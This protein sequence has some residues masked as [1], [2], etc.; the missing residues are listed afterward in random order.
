M[1]REALKLVR[2]IAAFTV[3]LFILF[4][5]PALSYG[6]G[7]TILAE[8]VRVNDGDTISVVLGGRREKVRLIG[9]DAPELHQRPWGMRAKRRLEELLNN[10][11]P[12]VTLEFDMVRRDKY[13][14]LLAY[15]WTADKRLVNLEMVKDG[16]ATLFTFPPNIRYADSLRK[17]QRN[18]KERGTGIWGQDR[19]KEKPEYYRRLHP[20]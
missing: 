11:G 1:N 5:R 8:I 17:A 13:G 9:I 19:L 15:L 6:Q 3:V 10:S 7:E 2:A 18:A 4:G 14:R 12:R 20:R 16:Y